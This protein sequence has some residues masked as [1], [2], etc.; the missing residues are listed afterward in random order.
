[1]FHIDPPFWGQ[2]RPPYVVTLPLR[3]VVGQEDKCPGRSADAT[4]VVVARTAGS[5][6]P[7]PA[8]TRFSRR[9]KDSTSAYVGACRRPSHLSWRRTAS[10]RHQAFSVGWAPVWHQHRSLCFGDIVCR[11]LGTS[12]SRSGSASSINRES[13]CE[14]HAPVASGGLGCGRCR[15][16]NASS[17]RVG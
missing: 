11:H 15:D 13:R 10:N 16:F 1:M 12:R 5:D 3:V 6:L 17:V 14:W 4:R 2:P 8:C 7:L 9:G